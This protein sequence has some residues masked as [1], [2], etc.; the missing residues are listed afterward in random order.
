MHKMKAGDL[1]R[2]NPVNMQPADPLLLHSNRAFKV[3]S[4]TEDGVNIESVQRSQMMHIVISGIRRNEL[5]YI[6]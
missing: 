5:Q 2:L 4:F 1:V 6:V 3:L